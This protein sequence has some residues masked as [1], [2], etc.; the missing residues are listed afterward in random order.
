MV[1]IFESQPSCGLIILFPQDEFPRVLLYSQ[2]QITSYSR[3]EFHTRVKRKREKFKTTC[4]M[5]TLR[6]YQMNG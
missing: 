4:L 6:S 5:T 1:S 3:K 2:L